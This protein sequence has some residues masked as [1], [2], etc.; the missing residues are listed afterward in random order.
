[1]SPMGHYI[2]SMKK[3]E[4][5]FSTEELATK[6]KVTPRTIRR[7]VHS[8][9]LPGYVRHEIKGRLMLVTVKQ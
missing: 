6:H 4:R 8:K 5:I 3:Q 7:W 2:C 1:M 9:N